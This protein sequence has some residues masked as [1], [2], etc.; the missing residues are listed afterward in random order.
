MV[1]LLIF[2]IAS[3]AS[4]NIFNSQWCSSVSY[5]LAESARKLE[6]EEHSSG[7]LR[8]EMERSLF[9]S[10]KYDVTVEEEEDF[11]IR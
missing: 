8:S 7:A 3:G 2:S 5:M 9:N 1:L 10:G 4:V 6:E 11:I